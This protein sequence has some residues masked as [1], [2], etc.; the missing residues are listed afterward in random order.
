MQKGREQ[1]TG[2]GLQRKRVGGG[3]RDVVESVI[4]LAPVASR[5][6]PIAYK[7]RRQ[8]HL[9]RIW[10][11]L[12]CA[13]LVGGA[14]LIVSPVCRAQDDQPPIP[15]DPT[16]LSDLIVGKEKAALG[17]ARSPKKLVDVY[18]DISDAHVETALAAIK[19]GD[20][21]AAERELDI[22]NK[23]IA[24]AMKVTSEQKENRRALSK[25]IEQRLY[26]QIRTLELIDALFPAERVAFADAALKH[27]RQL[28][29]QAL[30]ETFA[31]GEILQ[32]PTKPNNLPR[33]KENP[34]KTK[35]TPPPLAALNTSDTV[36]GLLPHE[37]ESRQRH[38]RRV[39]FSSNSLQFAGDYLSEEEADHVREAQEADA[40]IKVFMKIADRRLAAVTGAAAVADDKK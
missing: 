1:V 18:L 39:G 30:N 19:N 33:E 10:K 28:R 3:M 31:S 25:K 36:A 35:T 34:T 7:N 6:S 12:F 17:E 29:V 21:H 2:E 27:A 22:Y 24:E 23:A 9:I 8:N 15:V 16:P 11:L 38:A 14:F 32:D 13:L 37:Y 5:R 20:A 40:R 26:K 4:F